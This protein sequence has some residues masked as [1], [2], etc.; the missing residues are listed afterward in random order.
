MIHIGSGIPALRG[1]VD[2]VETLGR[3]VIGRVTR[4]RRNDRVRREA[5]RLL[6]EPRPEHGACDFCPEATAIGRSESHGT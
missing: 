6:R 1:V 5:P 4:R 3:L 2:V